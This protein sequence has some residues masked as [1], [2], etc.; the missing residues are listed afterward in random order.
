MVNHGISSMICFHGRTNYRNNVKR[1]PNNNQD[2]RDG[3]FLAWHL[4][5]DVY[6]KSHNQSRDNGYSGTKKE[7]A[8][9]KNTGA[10]FLSI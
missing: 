6:V 1:N 10:A 4:W 8:S 2:R 7:A 5:F 9:D 3:P